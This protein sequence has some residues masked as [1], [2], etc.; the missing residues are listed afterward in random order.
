[1]GDFETFAKKTS[2]CP[3][4]MPMGGIT[5]GAVNICLSYGIIGNAVDII[6]CIGLF[7]YFLV[8][9]RKYI[10]FHAKKSQSN[11]ASTFFIIKVLMI[12]LLV[13]QWIPLKI[14]YAQQLLGPYPTSLV[15]TDCIRM[16]TYLFMLGI[17]YLEW[18]RSLPNNH[19]I[20]ILWIVS[21]V[22]GCIK[23]HGLVQLNKSSPENLKIYFN[24]LAI[25]F[26]YFIVQ[27]ILAVVGV[28]GFIPAVRRLLE[29][30]PSQALSVG[31]E[32]EES[33]SIFDFIKLLL[34][35]GNRFAVLLL[36]VGIIMSVVKG[37][38]YMVVNSIEGA[39]FDIARGQKCN[40]V[41]KVRLYGVIA[42]VTIVYSLYAIGSGFSILY[43]FLGAERVI[44][45][46]KGIR[47]QMFE[48][49]LGQE[50]AYHDTTST[51]AISSRFSNDAERIKTLLADQ[52]PFFFENLSMIVTGLVFLF[53]QSPILT[54]Y[55]IGLVPITFGAT[56]FQTERL[57]AYVEESQDQNAAS[58]SKVQDVFSK[59]HTVL[60]YGKHE[61]EKSSF[62]KYIY[63]MYCT[64]RRKIIFSSVLVGIITLLSFSTQILA[65]YLGV[66]LYNGENGFK[67]FITFCLYAMNVVIGF[68][69]VLKVIPIMGE[70]IGGSLFVIKILDRRPQSP[71]SD[72]VGLLDLNVDKGEIEFR[73]VQFSYPT[74]PDRIALSNISFKIEPNSKVAL[75]G[76]SGAGKTTIVQLITR[77]YDPQ[78]GQI[79]ID[80]Q[81]IRNCNT[82]SIRK[83]IS[84]VGQST[85]LFASSVLENIA[86]GR[87]DN[88]IGNSTVKAEQVLKILRQGEVLDEPDL[89]EFLDE[90]LF[91]ADQASAHDFV[92]SKLTFKLGEDGKGLSGG[93]RQRVTIARAM[94]KDAKIVLLDEVTSALDQVSEAMVQKAIDKLTESR[95]VIIVAHRLHT[96][97]NADKIIV[98]EKGTI[99]AQGTHDELMEISE[100]Y[101]DLVLAAQKQEE[102][103]GDEPI[104]SKALNLLEEIKNDLKDD[105]ELNQL[106]ELIDQV[107]SDN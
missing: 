89:K 29:A 102:E 22:V 100:K 8:T 9:L 82:T 43:S 106:S 76:D 53:G 46:V 73:D 6:G 52:M 38:L 10:N 30:D 87:G 72:R 20:R 23:I 65:F 74:N 84:M 101:R 69:E 2:F 68:I 27:T 67:N 60:V 93:Q 71:E 42:H 80:G 105:D 62:A 12:V 78:R 54:I 1:M 107:I 75:V 34:K 90:I 98:L 37:Y 13:F 64:L 55:L 66:E 25:N 88:Q 19:F 5:N 44:N 16:F 39:L 18:N 77:F 40:P 79:I 32:H 33:A 70:A 61:Y 97:K 56:F 3:P 58:S 94:F 99:K 24:G 4:F 50:M 14:N 59:V 104:L 81:D 95:T 63:D 36:L 26:F 51:G 21:F 17:M 28:V 103:K 45:G 86:Y 85:G 96:I 7:I 92:Q 41:N 48:K 47:N 35:K 49:L 57:E 11:I 91:S 83:N 31:E 15:L